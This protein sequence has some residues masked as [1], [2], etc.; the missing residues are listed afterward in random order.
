MAQASQEKKSEALEFSITAT[1]EDVPPIGG[2]RPNEVQVKV[3]PF[4]TQGKPNA[5]SNRHRHIHER[6]AL[7]F[8][9]IENAGIDMTRPITL[10]AGSQESESPFKWRL[11]ASSLLDPDTTKE[12]VD[13]DTGSWELRK[14]EINGQT[15][16]TS[17]HEEDGEHRISIFLR[18]GGMVSIEVY[19]P[20]RR[21][22]E[23]CRN[24]PSAGRLDAVLAEYELPL[25][26][27]GAVIMDILQRQH[28]RT[29]Q[30]GSD[31]AKSPHS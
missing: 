2:L 31:P 14:N 30:Q 20:R 6:I 22:V 26:V 9:D 12:L 21:E 27:N 3:G 16:D 28:R 5:I 10:S 18:T 24:L 1:R 17:F 11:D 8:E 25:F 19:G 4:F 29:F 13:T 7:L 23:R 15:I